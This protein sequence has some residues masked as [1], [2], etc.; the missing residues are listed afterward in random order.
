MAPLE[1]WEKV[2]VN[3]ELFIETVHGQ[4]N[5]IDCHDGVQSIE[6]EVAH[7]GLVAYPSANPQ[8]TCGECHP[9]VIKIYPDSLHSD[10]GGYWTVLE[11]RTIPENHDELEEMFGNHCSECHA[12]CGEC[13]VSQPRLVG[14][15]FVDGHVFNATPSM[16]RNCTACHG[17]R[18]GNE[19]LG[20]HEGLMPDVHFRQ[21]RMTCV[22]CHSGHDL[23]GAP[24]NCQECHQGPEY[25][26]ISPPDHRYDGIQSPSCE[27][28]HAAVTVGNDGIIMHEQHGGELQCQVC[29]SIEYSSC[30]G[31]HVQIS[32][33][34]GNPY[35][36]TE[37]SYLGLYIGLNPLK[38]YNRPYKYVLLRH[39]PVDEDSFSFYGN[40]L[41]P[42]Y[43]QLPTWTYASPHN[44]QRNTP[45]TESCGACHGNPELF[46]TAEKVAENEIAANQDV[47]VREIPASIFS[48]DVTIEVTPSVE[49]T[50][51]LEITSTSE[52]TGT[53]NSEKET[54]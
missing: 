17:S 48:N 5:C 15:G 21:G 24:D 36:T 41:L 29:H 8:E 9:D 54:P 27:S 50:S 34:T 35:Y 37:G 12:T 51:T 30:D 46:L 13:H 11:Q 42:N 40:N 1:P 33:E 23:H 49:I 45:Q 47:I 26:D 43:D 14:S 25:G 32:D 52:I 2:F 7:E 39:V 44:I 20:K 4:I 38:S 18:V 31:C 28:C 22:D 53:E 19:Y 10:L 6:K 16:T 3:A